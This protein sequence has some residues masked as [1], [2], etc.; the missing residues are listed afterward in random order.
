[1]VTKTMIWNKKKCLWKPM[2]RSNIECSNGAVQDVEEGYLNQPVLVT[3]NA[4]A[5]AL[6]SNLGA[7]MSCLSYVERKYL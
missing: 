6:T 5:D 2:N 4:K 3:G 1:M 7:F